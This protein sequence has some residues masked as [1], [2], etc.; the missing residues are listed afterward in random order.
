[1]SSIPITIRIS[2]TEFDQLEVIAMKR[3]VS[4]GKLLQAHVR[5]GLKPTRVIRPTRPHQGPPRAITDDDI[6]EWVREAEAGATNNQIAERA[7]VSKS[8][9]SRYLIERGVRRNRPRKAA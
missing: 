1:M 5:A 3:G 9:V 4:V 7:G 8:L 6:D 2:S